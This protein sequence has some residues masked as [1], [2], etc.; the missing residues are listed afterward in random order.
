MSQPTELVEDADEEEILKLFDSDSSSSDADEDESSYII[1]LIERALDTDEY[2]VDNYEEMADDEN[3]LVKASA[4]VFPEYCNVDATWLEK[5]LVKLNSVAFTKGDEF[6][7][8]F[9]KAFSAVHM[10]WCLF[11]QIPAEQLNQA[12]A[13]LEIILKTMVRITSMDAD[14]DLRYT[15][16]AIFNDESCDFR[17]ESVR[18]TFTGIIRNSSLNVKFGI[19]KVAAEKVRITGL[20]SSDLDSG[21]SS[22]RI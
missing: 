16:A 3:H 20:A 22:P 11:T 6:I 7:I 18:E 1:P 13:A 15:P 21:Y 12:K 5:F 2:V 19:Y 17:D 8:K 9:E 10:I 14:D 4:F